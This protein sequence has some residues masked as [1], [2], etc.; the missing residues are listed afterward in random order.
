MTGT[1]V[2]DPG[3]QRAL[4]FYSRSWRERH[5]AD[6]VAMMMDAADHGEQPLSPA[7]RRSLMWAGLRQRFASRPYLWLWAVSSA[8]SMCVFAWAAWR[9][10]RIGL[11]ADEHGTS[12]AVDLWLWP[13][14]LGAALLFL[15]NIATLTLS[16]LYQP[17]FPRRTV[18][19]AARGWTAWLPFVG[20]LGAMFLAPVLPV[21]PLLAITA[22]AAGVG[23]YRRTGRRQ[24]RALS[25][26]SAAA[27]ALGLLALI[28]AATWL[29]LD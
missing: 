9:L 25:G 1:A 27:L 15:V 10:G 4:R 28:P 21:G 23:L 2:S 12:G 5:G 19:P 7:G 8:L 29:L 14:A 13:V 6:V 26:L 18:R 24:Y 20:A 16:A 3:Y 11:Y 22:L 17:P